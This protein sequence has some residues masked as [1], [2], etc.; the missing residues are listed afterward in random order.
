MLS[1]F[2]SAFKTV[3]SRAGVHVLQFTNNIGVFNTYTR[4]EIKAFLK[5]KIYT[6]SIKTPGVQ[7]YFLGIELSFGLRT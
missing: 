1:N 4:T 6:D 3:F 2:I 7:T 5:I